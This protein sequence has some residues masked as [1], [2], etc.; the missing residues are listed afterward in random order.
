MMLGVASM[1]PVQAGV[2]NCILFFG[3]KPVKKPT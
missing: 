3:K 1:G 2:I